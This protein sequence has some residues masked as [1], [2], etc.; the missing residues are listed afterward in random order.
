MRSQIE[1]AF[2]LL[3]KN[4][5]IRLLSSASVPYVYSL[6]SLIFTVFV[7]LSFYFHYQV[8]S[9]TYSLPL[10]LFLSIAS[11]L[12]SI[13]SVFPNLL[14]VVFRV[15]F[16][17]APSFLFDLWSFGTRVIMRIDL[18]PSLH[19]HPMGGIGKDPILG[20][21]RPNGIDSAISSTDWQ[22]H[23]ISR[24]TRHRH[25]FISQAR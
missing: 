20:R 24:K 14:A 4:C 11:S 15:Y 21:E 22:I 8:L 13:L 2:A 19:G 1:P 9:F 23:S 5:E 7:P 10:F 17:V 16:F 12:R 3:Q 6:I 18:L 25:A